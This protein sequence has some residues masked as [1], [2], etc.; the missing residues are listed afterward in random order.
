[1]TSYD[2]HTVSGVAW[3]VIGQP[4]EGIRY[5][6][7]FG[8]LKTFVTWILEQKCTTFIAHNGKGYDFI[9]LAAELERQGGYNVQKNKAGTKVMR[10]TYKT[11][12]F[13]DSLNHFAGSPLAKLPK[14]FG[15][16]VHIRK[17]YFPYLQ[18]FGDYVGELPPASFF[19]Y[20]GWAD[21]KQHEFLA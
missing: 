7:G 3:H 5:E 14:T 10:M 9:L 13:I 15:L 20:E 12:I 4:E 6:D 8:C 17:G 2:Q 18:P 19:C 16:D 1:M 11:L 21:V